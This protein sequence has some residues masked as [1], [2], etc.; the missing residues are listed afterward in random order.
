MCSCE[1][2]EGFFFLPQGGS[3]RQSSVLDTQGGSVVIEKSFWVQLGLH[4]VKLPSLV[5]VV[6]V[7]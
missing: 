4:V 6:C 3:H 5:Y 7:L 1:D 2:Q